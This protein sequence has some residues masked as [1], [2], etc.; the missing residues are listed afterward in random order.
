MWGRFLSGGEK[1]TTK[2]KMKKKKKKFETEGVN[3]LCIFLAGKT[4][5]S[6]PRCAGVIQLMAGGKLPRNRARGY[7]VTGIFS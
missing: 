4:S 6:A 7:F 2:R 1:K 3:F 5:M